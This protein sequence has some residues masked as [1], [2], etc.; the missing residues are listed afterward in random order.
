[1]Q[2]AL[3]ANATYP[4]RSERSD[5]AL[6]V[7]SLQAGW[8]QNTHKGR[9]PG[10]RKAACCD[11]GSGSSSSGRAGARYAFVPRCAGTTRTWLCTG[12]SPERRKPVVLFCCRATEITP[13]RSN[14]PCLHGSILHMKVPTNRSPGN[15]QEIQQLSR[16]SPSLAS[17]LGSLH[18]HPVLKTNLPPPTAQPFLQR[19]T[20]GAT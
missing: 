20:G 2:S 18:H 5:P 1:M 12:K 19:S 16:H 10:R 4:A 9:H 14:A 17:K 13:T 6:R 3:P 15:L 7:D 11:Q 8:A